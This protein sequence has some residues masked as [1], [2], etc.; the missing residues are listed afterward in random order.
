MYAFG[1]K[2]GIPFGRN[3]IVENFSSPALAPKGRLI[4][5]TVLGSTPKRRVA[6]GAFVCGVG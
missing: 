1:V 5:C 3:Q 4:R 2:A 6:S